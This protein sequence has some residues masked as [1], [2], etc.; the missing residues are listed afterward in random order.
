MKEQDTNHLE[1][2]PI[3]YDESINMLVSN[4]KHYPIIEDAQFSYG[5]KKENNER[6]GGEDQKVALL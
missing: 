3:H 1:F 5:T 4:S 2:D 6:G